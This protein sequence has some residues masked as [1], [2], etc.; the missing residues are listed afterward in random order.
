MVNYL[1]L[2]ISHAVLILAFWRIVLRDDLDRDPGDTDG[3]R[4]PRRPHAGS[5]DA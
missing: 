5:S 1:P 3:E 4:R 2:A